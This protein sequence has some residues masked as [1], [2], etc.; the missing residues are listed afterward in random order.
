MIISGAGGWPSNFT[1]AVTVPAVAGSTD[2]PAGAAGGGAALPPHAS[3][4]ARNTVEA[5][6]PNERILYYFRRRLPWTD[7]ALI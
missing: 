2:G 5:T 3:E 1:I 7:A 6:N 4:I